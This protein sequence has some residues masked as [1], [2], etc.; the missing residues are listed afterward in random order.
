MLNI[1]KITNAFLLFVIHMGVG[2]AEYY[3]TNLAK[4]NPSTNKLQI[5]T[6]NKKDVPAPPNFPQCPKA[7]KYFKAKTSSTYV[8]L[9]D[10][11]D[12]IETCKEDVRI[13]LTD[14]TGFEDGCVGVEVVT[15]TC[16]ESI[17]GK[18]LEFAVDL[19]GSIE[20]VNRKKINY[21]VVQLVQ[22][23]IDGSPTPFFHANVKIERAKNHKVKLS[24]QLQDLLNPVL[25]TTDT[26]I[27]W[28]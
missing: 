20:K 27:R 7:T 2:H 18:T 10:F 8:N 17:G 23:S 28:K 14:F 3:E 26:D 13:P 5:L 4:I 6:I 16:S 11:S 22:A 12:I 1:F 15:V 19:A 25:L 9:L 24:S 21:D